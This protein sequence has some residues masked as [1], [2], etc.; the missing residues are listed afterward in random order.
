MGVKSLGF[1]VLP[2]KGRVL[3]FSGLFS[4]TLMGAPEHPPATEVQRG[5]FLMGTAC[6][7]TAF[8][9]DLPATVR[10]IE[11]ALDRIQEAEALLS[12]WRDD[13]E[14]AQLNRE[15]SRR[16]VPAQTVKAG[17]TNPVET[18]RHE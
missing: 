6:R 12:T 15:A 8:G 7:I 18:L 16:S 4:L 9:S 2:S 11:T 14:L 5:R 3:L 13:T 10:A 17:L 1:Y